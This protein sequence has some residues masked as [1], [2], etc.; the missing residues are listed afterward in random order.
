MEQIKAAKYK[1]VAV[2]IFTG[3][4]SEKNLIN[5]VRDI[6]QKLRGVVPRDK[7]VFF[8]STSSGCWNNKEV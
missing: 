8:D 1:R 7:I 4:K 6:K 5:E 3:D 2:S